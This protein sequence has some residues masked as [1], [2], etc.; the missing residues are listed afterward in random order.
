MKKSKLKEIESK[1]NNS[2]YAKLNMSSM[3]R[4]NMIEYG[5]DVNEDRALSDF[6][7]GFKPAQRRLLA[8]MCD[9][10]AFAGSMSYKSARITGD[11][12]GKY[13]PHSDS[14]GVLA[15]MATSYCPIVFGKGNL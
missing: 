2:K 4:N 10:H 5:K 8:S 14:Y 12:M 11:S 3:V 6:R 9:L 7:D 13:H 15:G 1:I